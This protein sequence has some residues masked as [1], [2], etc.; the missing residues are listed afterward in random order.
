MAENGERR[1]SKTP[2]LQ[3]R[4]PTADRDEKETG[5]PVVNRTEERRK[6]REQGKKVKRRGK[7]IK[8]NM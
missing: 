7:G 8:W 3:C 6:S 4:S 2:S 1:V 5:P